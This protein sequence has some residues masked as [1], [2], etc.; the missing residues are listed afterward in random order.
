[1]VCPSRILICL[2]TASN[3]P[4]VCKPCQMSESNYCVSFTDKQMECKDCSHAGIFP[5]A[6]LHSTFV[7]DTWVRVSVVYVCMYLCVCVFCFTCLNNSLNEWLQLRQRTLYSC[8]LVR[9]H[10]QFQSQKKATSVYITVH[11]THQVRFFFFLYIF[12]YICRVVATV[13]AVFVAKYKS[14]KMFQRSS[15]NHTFLGHL[16][17]SSGRDVPHVAFISHW[18]NNMIEWLVL[19]EVHRDTFSTRLFTKHSPA[20]QSL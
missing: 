1:M 6:S 20:A 13:A 15:E 4:S 5:S 16:C 2:V 19:E 18:K 17:F 11:K 12:I 14:A 10:V 8:E 9:K 7:V 3:R